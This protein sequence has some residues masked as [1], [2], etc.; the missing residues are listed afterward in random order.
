MVDGDEILRERIQDRPVDWPLERGSDGGADCACVVSGGEVVDLPGRGDVVGMSRRLSGSRIRHD[1][2]ADGRRSVFRVHVLRCRVQVF[3]RGRHEPL[4]FLDPVREVRCRDVDAA[5]SGVKSLERVCIVG[6]REL[7]RGPCVL[8][9]PQ[10][11]GEAIAFVE[12]RFDH[13][14]QGGGNRSH[15]SHTFGVHKQILSCYLWTN[16]TC[17]PARC[18]VRFATEAHRLDGCRPL[19]QRSWNWRT[20]L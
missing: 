9:G 7:A 15:G 17:D 4:R 10:R 2:C 16:G 14:L 6:R 19:K 5:H 1:R 13:G 18:S 3:V 11:D 12:A 20:G 8:V